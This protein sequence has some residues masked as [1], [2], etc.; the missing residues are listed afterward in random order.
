[1]DEIRKAGATAA[2]L[3]EQLLAFSQR[4]K[5]PAETLDLNA[6]VLASKG[7]LARLLGEE[8]ILETDLDGA[9]HSIMATSGGIQQ[10]LMN[11]AANAR[12]AMPRGGTVIV[13]TRNTTARDSEDLASVP[14]LCA[15][16]S[17][18]DT[19][20][21]IAR[22]HVG[23]LF[24][25]FFTTKELRNNTGMGL[26]TVYGLVKQSGGWI[27]VDSQVGHGATFCLYFPAAPSAQASLREPEKRTAPV[28]SGATILLA[29]DQPEIRSFACEVLQSSGYN[30]IEAVD[31]VQALERSLDFPGRIDLLVSDVIMPNMR[32][33]ELAARLRA[34]RSGMAVL[35]MSGYAPEVV[36]HTSDAETIVL[37]KPFSP[38]QLVS[39]G[40]NAL[41]GVR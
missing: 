19:G 12:D 5:I 6:I 16:L 34:S 8:V 23:H 29:E 38:E 7:M 13:R 15:V 1:V 22:E 11:L 4:R 37:A 2:T 3:T 41:L 39:A 30:V 32:G 35:F 21:G 14:I 26:A 24:E 28:R 17:V 36:N 40:E 20:Q 31:S 27:S 33:T 25:P 9:L 18:R 10:I